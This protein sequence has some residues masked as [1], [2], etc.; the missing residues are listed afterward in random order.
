MIGFQSVQLLNEELQVW[1]VENRCWV[2]GLN[3]ARDPGLPVPSSAPLP[4]LPVHLRISSEV[5]WQQSDMLLGATIIGG[6]C[7][8]VSE[9]GANGRT[10]CGPHTGDYLSISPL[11]SSLVSTAFPCADSFLTCP[12]SFVNLFLFSFCFPPFNNIFFL[13]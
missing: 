12:S 2:I 5:W 6:N 1:G 3:R 9:E 4:S 11:L 13:L 7:Y 10:E 8:M